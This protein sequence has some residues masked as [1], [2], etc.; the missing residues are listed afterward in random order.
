VKRRHR[1]YCGAGIKQQSAENNKRKSRQREVVVTYAASAKAWPS[2]RV[3]GDE[4]AKSG[5]E[6]SN[7][8]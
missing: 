8:A 2:R 4:E 7:L 1:K 5:R 6:I 3:D